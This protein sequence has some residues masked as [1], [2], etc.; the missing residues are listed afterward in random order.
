MGFTTQLKGRIGAERFGL[1]QVTIAC[2]GRSAASS[3]RRA[4]DALYI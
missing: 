4:G 3:R 2:A 1:L